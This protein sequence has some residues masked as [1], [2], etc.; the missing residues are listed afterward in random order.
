MDVIFDTA[1]GALNIDTAAVHPWGADLRAML[2]RHGHVVNLKGV[3][4][5]L[6]ITADG[7]PVFD[8]TLP[9]PGVRYKQTD[10][11][12]LAT[13]RVVWAPDQVI[14]AEAWC[15]TTSG[16]V[17]T[18]SA[19]FTA[20]RPPQPYPSWAWADGAWQAPVVYPDDGGD[21]TWSEPTQAWVASEAD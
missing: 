1:T 18:A 3:E 20:P 14:A 8:L 12:V 5:G 10:Q 6:T 21:Y 17:L 2:N 11:D 13:G 9:P 7:L 15:K 19:S 16:H 4:M